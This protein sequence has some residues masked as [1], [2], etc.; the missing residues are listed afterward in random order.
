MKKIVMKKVTKIVMKKMTKIVMK[1]VMKIVMKKVT[2][3]MMKK[4]TKI[5]MKKVKVTVLKVMINALTNV[6]T[7]V[8]KTGVMITAWNAK[9]AGIV[10]VVIKRN[11]KNH[12]KNVKYAMKDNKVK[13]MDHL[14][15]LLTK[16]SE[17]MNVGVIVKTLAE[18][19]LRTFKMK[20]ELGL[21][22][23]TQ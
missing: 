19:N 22:T 21:V 8:K 17:T 14:N 18:V 6:V 15:H 20:V 2:K 13:I 10:K 12:V 16:Y 4:V 3:I 5:V 11:V 7:T 9:M 23:L 1:K